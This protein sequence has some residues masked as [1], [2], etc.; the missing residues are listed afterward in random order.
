MVISDTMGG[1]FEEKG[2]V[3]GAGEH[4]STSRTRELYSDRWVEN[5]LY[6]GPRLLYNSIICAL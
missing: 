3:K 2:R 5:Y 4:N 1:L 6:Y